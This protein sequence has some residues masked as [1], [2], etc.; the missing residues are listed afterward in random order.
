MA[1]GYEV[2]LHGAI[3]N[4]TALHETIGVRFPG[5]G[6]WV[7]YARGEL[8]GRVLLTTPSTR[9]SAMVQKLPRRRIVYLTGW[10]Y[11][12]GAHNIYRDCDLVLPL[13]DHADFDELVH[14]ARASGASKIYTVHGS[15]KFAA[16]LRELGLD[17][18]HLAGHPQDGARDEARG[19]SERAAECSP[20]AGPQR[21]LFE[22]LE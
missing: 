10:A 13:S 1:R 14:T 12:P 5:P 20:P 9:K 19:A 17:A 18:E 21:S 6:R 7:R 15:E 11:H 8:A 3:A 4:M 16:H 2:A 22:E